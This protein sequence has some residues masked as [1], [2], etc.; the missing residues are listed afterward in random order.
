[1]ANVPNDQEILDGIRE[2]LTAIKVPGAETAAARDDV[3]GPRRRLARPRRARQGARGPLRD[4]DRRR[5]AEGDRDASATPSPR[6]RSSCGRRRAC[7]RELAPDDR[8]H[9]AGVVSSD[10]RGRRTRS[11]TP[12]SPS[13]RASPTASAPCA[14]FDPEVGD[15]A[16]R[17]PAAPTA[18][19]SSR[20]ARPIQAAEE[21]GLPDGIEPERLGVIIGTGVGGLL[22]RCSASAADLLEGGDRAVS[23]HF[24]PMMMPNAAA[25]TIA[26]RA[27]R[28]RA[29]ASRS[30][31]RCA[32]GAHAIG[33]ATRMIAARRGRRGP[34][35][36]H[37]GG[38]HRRLPGR[39]PAHGRA[40]QG[41]R[42]A[43]VRRPPRRLRDGRGRGRARARAR[44]PR[45]R[46]RRDDL[47]RIA[48]YAASND[49][50]HITQPDPEGTGARKAMRGAL[51][52]AGVGPSDVGY[53]NAHGT[54]TPYNDRIETA[55]DQAVFN[56][57]TTPPPVSSTKSAI[58][59]LLGAAGARRGAS[60][61][62]RRSAA[63]CCP[64]TL[65]YAGARPRVRSGLRPRRARARRPAW[66][67]PCP[68]RSASAARTPAWRSPRHDVPITSDS[69]RS[70]A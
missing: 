31:R 11:S 62:S 7:R 5:T 2:E 66:S 55:G 13:A 32:T 24:V 37:R 42:L 61:A 59:H 63:A 54:G 3:G 10:R 60:R 18:S 28:Q 4:P 68:T 45:T 20:S 26:M 52:D 67:W 30:R 53:V 25:G 46:P 21:A 50:F 58:G 47:G 17:R 14:D 48:G 40:L 1:M 41:G 16:P 69:R 15:V 19:R 38:A 39:L 33:E 64:P 51:A 49:A 56:G 12:C 36:R 9:R 65:N 35:G 57:S 29:R 23:P 43:P 8:R 44:G 22:T 6:C 70:T 34:R 27:R